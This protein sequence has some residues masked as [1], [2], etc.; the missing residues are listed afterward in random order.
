M[1]LS[2]SPRTFFKILKGLPAGLKE[3]EEK[4]MRRAIQSLYQSRLADEKENPD[5]IKAGRVARIARGSG[6]AE[7]DV[8][9]A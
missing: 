4:N 8:P 9:R 3:I 5:E 2:G 7:A 6:T 1:G